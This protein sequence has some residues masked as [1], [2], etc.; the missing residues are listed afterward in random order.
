M[1]RKACEYFP[2][3]VRIL[4]M[5]GHA[6]LARGREEEARRWFRRALQFHHAAALYHSEFPKTD[7]SIHFWQ[8]AFHI[9]AVTNG[10]REAKD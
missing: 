5:F 8:F 4:D 6:L 1:L 3:S 10:G 2:E 7:G 9:D